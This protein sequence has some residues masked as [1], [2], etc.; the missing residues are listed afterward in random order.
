MRQH[1]QYDAYAYEIYRDKPS[2]EHSEKNPGPNGQSTLYRL[3]ESNLAASAFHNNNGRH[4]G[5][6]AITTGIGG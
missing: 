4:T 1:N 3:I 6:G 5:R 2:I